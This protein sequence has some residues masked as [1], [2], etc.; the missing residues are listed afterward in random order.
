MKLRQLAVQHARATLPQKQRGVVMIVALIVLVA[1]TIASIGLLRSVDTSSTISGNLAIKKDLYRQSN[2]GIQQAQMALNTLRGPDF[3]LPLTDA[4]GS[5][6][7]ASATQAVDHRGLPQLL[8][9]AALPSSP[10]TVT[11]WA[12]EL[13]VPVP[14]DSGTG[15]TTSGGY[16]FRYMAERLCPAGGVPDDTT[17]PCRIAAGAGTSACE[18]NSTCLTGVGTIYIRLTLRVDGPKNSTSYFQ[19][20][21]L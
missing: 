4:L 3:E 2:I 12:G 5:N 18:T 8:V 15:I 13:V 6:Y 17:N 16:V 10:G 1:L 11:G 14:V 21:L 7:Y 20:M 19:A 9:N